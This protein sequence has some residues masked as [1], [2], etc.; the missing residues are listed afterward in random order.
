MWFPVTASMSVQV[1]VQEDLRASFP[2]R[3]DAGHKRRPQRFIH[4]ADG[5]E[6]EH[7]SLQINH[8]ARRLTQRAQA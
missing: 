5:R 2:R 3:V 1:H 6:L 7:A 4:E 8:E